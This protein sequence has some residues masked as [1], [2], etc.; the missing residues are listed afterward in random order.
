MTTTTE[1]YVTPEQL[2]EELHVPVKTLYSW[3]YQRTGPPSFRVGKHVRYPRS[4][5]DRWISERLAVDQHGA[6]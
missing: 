6:A 2:A 4:G 3:R 1:A 5:I